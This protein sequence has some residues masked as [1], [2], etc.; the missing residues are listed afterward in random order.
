MECYTISAESFIIPLLSTLLAAFWIMVPAYVPNPV[1]ALCGGGTPVDF[2]R[3]YSDGRRLLG[4]G[5]TFR[6]LVCGVLAGVAV[7]A[8]QIWLAGTWGWTFLPQHT[9]ASIIILPLGALLGDMGKSFV[10]RRLGKNRGESWPIADQYDLVAGA[11]I[12]ML[13]FD[14][15]WLFTYVTWPI[16][17]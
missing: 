11:F 9:A 10:K 17:I 16:L 13:V 14:P 4:E 6:G 12:L 15:S 5:K 2:G 8:L 1:A 7:G 3:N